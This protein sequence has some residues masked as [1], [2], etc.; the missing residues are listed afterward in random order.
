MLITIK[1][2]VFK[3]AKNSGKCLGRKIILVSRLGMC[4]L[5]PFLNNGN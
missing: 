2:I 3:I 1:D 4:L 5:V